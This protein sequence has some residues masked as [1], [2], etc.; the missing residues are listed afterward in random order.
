MTRILMFRLAG[1]IGVLLIAV[2]S[3]LPG[4]LRPDT[5]FAGIIDHFLA[6]ALS[7][8]VL[9]MGWPGQ[10]VSITVGLFGL[11]A[12][13]EAAQIWVPG[14]HAELATV[15]T[16]GVGAFVGAAIGHATLLRPRARFS[17]RER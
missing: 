15:L 16:N 5:G 2:L 1:I 13:S 11:G 8:L 14:R 9:S 17:Q 10:A 4:E 6:Y 3:V 12:I 7:A